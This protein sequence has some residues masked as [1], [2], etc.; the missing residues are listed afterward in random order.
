MG[1]STLGK[2]LFGI[3]VLGIESHDLT[4]FGSALRRWLVYGVLGGCWRWGGVQRHVVPVRPALEAVLARQGGPYV[5]GVGE[6][7]TRTA[8]GRMREAER[9]VLL[10]P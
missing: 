10:G 5:R 2:K 4:P 8:Y 1:G 6:G 7:L 9:W 3:R